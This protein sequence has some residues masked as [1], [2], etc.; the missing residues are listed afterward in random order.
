[1]LILL[2]GTYKIKIVVQIKFNARQF[3]DK[4]KRK[5][6]LRRLQSVIPKAVSDL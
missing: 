4:E 1:M 2:I 5:K 6:N 3:S